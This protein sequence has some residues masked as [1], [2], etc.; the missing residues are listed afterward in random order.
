MTGER[1]DEGGVLDPDD[2]GGEIDLDVDDEPGGE[3][4]ALRP[5]EAVRI[6]R[7]SIAII[8]SI[9]TL[10][11]ALIVCTALLLRRAVDDM[12]RNQASGGPMTE[13]VLGLIILAL[14]GGFLRMVEFSVAE[15]VGYRY[16][17]SLRMV[18]YSHLQ[19]ISPRQMQHNSR[20]AILLRF[21]GDLTTI[22]VYISRGLA[23]GIVASI[24]LVGGLSVLAFI[25][26]EMAL[27]TGG[28]LMASA[29]L[30][31]AEGGNVRRLTRKARRQRANLIT[32]LADQIQGMAVL[33][34]L[35][36]INGE[37]NRLGQQNH[38]LTS[39]LIR[40]ARVRGVLRAIST[41][42]GSLAVVAVLVVGSYDVSSGDTTVGAVVAAMIIVRQ[43]VRPMRELGLAHDYWQSAKV[44][45]EK[46]LSFLQRPYR[47]ADGIER[48]KLRVPR[49]HISL[50][51]VHLKGSLHGI[52]QDVE[53]RRIVAIMGPNGAGKSSLLAVVARL[54]DPDQGAVLIDDQEIAAC[55]LRSCSRHISLMSESL[56][57]LRGTL[58]RNV[59]YRWREAPESELQRV[60]EICALDAVI[61]Q[62]PDGMDGHV[63]EGGANLSGGHAARVA[64]ARAIVG[65]PRVLL[66]DEPTNNLDRATK[67][68]FREIVVRYGGT[69]LIATHDPDEAALADV[70]WKMDD[71]R[72][73]QV[74]MGSDFRAA[75]SSPVSMPAWGLVGEERA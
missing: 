21:V 27:V 51:D 24:T 33:Q 37:Y 45:R 17:E 48:P 47:E 36:R 10:E 11:A 25:D 70:V 68:R 1:R 61:D 30:S 73:S 74:I 23:R 43:M 54:A 67:E 7:R 72:I 34:A 5:D 26:L 14:A 18:M 49:G 12:V 15:T 2:F 75:L 59:L 63:K 57:L 29:A 3:L 60:T 28:L 32:N 13:L 41:A 6:P 42:T 53:P 62:L 58:R 8:A 19:R 56:P 35:G 9:G 44:S 31:L 71:G 52:T 65:S 38:R 66:L 16:V 55:S 22:R 20:G 50:R 39:A 4:R 40:Y 64:F 46:V 69:V